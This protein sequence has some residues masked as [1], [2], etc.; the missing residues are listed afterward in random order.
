MRDK[1][2]FLESN[3]KP[4]TH[5]LQ[6]KIENREP[7]LPRMRELMGKSTVGFI[8]EFSHAEWPK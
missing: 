6:T 4:K 5:H 2:Q 7:F 8:I 3:L 1:G